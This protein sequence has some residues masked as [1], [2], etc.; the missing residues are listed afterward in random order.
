MTGAMKLASAD[1]TSTSQTGRLT[2]T[3]RVSSGGQHPRNFTID[4]T[5]RFLLA[6]NRDTDNVVIFR[7]DQQ[8]GQPVPTGQELKLSMP[9]GM[10]IVAA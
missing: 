5:S 7:I 6:A 4:P 9:M 1:A 2:F 8:T 10:K 3:A